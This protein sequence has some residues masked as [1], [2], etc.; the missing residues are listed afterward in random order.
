MRTHAKSP[1]TDE[2]KVEEEISERTSPP[3]QIIYRAV[4]DEGEHE[5]SRG[6]GALAWSGLAAGLSM[7]FSLIGQ[8]LLQ[9]CLPKSAWRPLLTNF[10]YTLGFLIVILGRQ[11]LFTE[12]TLTA[13]LPYL[14]R[15]KF[16]VLLNVGR[17]WGIVLLTNLVGTFIF[18]LV[19]GSTRIFDD[20]VRAAC[21]EIGRGA[22]E[23][24][25]S[26]TFFR[27]IFAGWLLALMVWLL[28]F[29]ESAR[30]W[31]IIIISYL[32]GLGKFSHVVA[33]GTESFYLVVTREISLWQSL[34]KFVVPTLIGN[35]IGGV[36]MVAML[37]HA[38][39]MGSGRD[40]GHQKG[41]HEGS[42]HFNN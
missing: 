37:A 24:S 17:L 39:F 10:G 21:T 35:S 3:G 28:P 31:V 42:R 33:G 9:T 30:I 7:G 40:E 2:D 19:V 27:A 29:A 14:A 4:Q 32:V 12:N 34:G 16:D 38:Q 15:K 8:A 1:H 22:M 18:S 6:N 5:L 13:V 36:T 25:W 41:A 23:T 20:D 11:Q 26:I